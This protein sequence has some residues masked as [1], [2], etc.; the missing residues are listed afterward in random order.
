M[1]YLTRTFNGQINGSNELLPGVYLGGT[2]LFLLAKWEEAETNWV[3]PTRLGIFRWFKF[4]LKPPY[5][6]AH[7][8]LLLAI[9]DTS[10]WT[11][12]VKFGLKTAWD[13]SY[14]ILW[15]ILKYINFWRLQ[16]RSSNLSKKDAFRK[17]IFSR[18]RSD[19][20]LMRLGGFR[21]ADT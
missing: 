12:F 6:V 15:L 21:W 9:W 16:G 7:G 4:T 18:W 5:T 13:I 2:V 11:S 3:H 17:L 10:H 19:K 14:D 20:A 8:N 1:Q